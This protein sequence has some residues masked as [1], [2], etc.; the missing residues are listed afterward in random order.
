MTEAGRGPLRNHRWSAPSHR[1]RPTA[2]LL[3]AAWASWTISPSD[4]ESWDSSVTAFRCCSYCP[5]F[6]WWSSRQGFLSCRGIKHRSSSFVS[7]G[8][9]AMSSWS[10]P[11]PSTILAGSS[12]WCWLCEA[13]QDFQATKPELRTALQVPRAVSS[14]LF[15]RTKARVR[16]MSRHNSHNTGLWNKITSRHIS[17]SL[18]FIIRKKYL[19][20]IVTYPCHVIGIE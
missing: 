9:R 2:V 7:A 20:D 15:L 18:G 8:L 5:L 13:R 19:T 1:A 11:I 16:S 4:R 3:W 17:T 10:L 6:A 14:F 12:T